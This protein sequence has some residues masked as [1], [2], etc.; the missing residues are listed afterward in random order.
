M[1]KR[2]LVF[3]AG[4]ILFWSFPGFSQEPR[5]YFNGAANLFINGKKQEAVAT[6]QDGIRRYPSNERLQALLKAILEAKQEKQPPQSGNQNQDEQKQKQQEQQQQQ[7]Q[8]P[9][10]QEKQMAK[11]EAERILDVLKNSEKDVQKKLR[12]RQAVRAKTDKDW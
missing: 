2:R 1:K 7:Q 11:A 12:V 5:V 9:R 3:V 10:N 6:L 8:Q 4:L